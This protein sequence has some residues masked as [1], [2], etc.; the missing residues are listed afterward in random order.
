MR[1]LVVEDERKVAHFIKKGLEEQAYAVDVAYNG[2][3]GE[4]LSRQ[5]EYDLIILDILL[6]KQDGLDTCRRLRESKIGIPILMLTALDQTDDKVKGLDSGADDY[7][8]KPFDFAELL[9]RVRALLRRTHKEKTGI[10]RIADLILNP[11]SHEARRA[12]K[13]IRLTA[14]EFALLEYLMRNKGRVLSRSS[15]SEHVWDI[16]FDRESNVI[17]VY[18]KLLRQKVDKGFDRPLIHTV[19]G[20]GY[21]I[22]EETDV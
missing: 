12:G 1:I 8:T 7:L 19:I 4:L 11:A 3:D 6:P 15:I 2:I 18:V 16:D 5:N 14:K 22:R 9:A 13:V 10:L 21:V 20:V 17:D